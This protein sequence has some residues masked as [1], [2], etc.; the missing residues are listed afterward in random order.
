MS[1]YFFILHAT[2]I[3]TLFIIIILQPFQ[4]KLSYNLVTISQT[5]QLPGVFWEEAGDAE[6]LRTTHQ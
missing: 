6:E 3:S 1:R 5:V 2:K 4:F